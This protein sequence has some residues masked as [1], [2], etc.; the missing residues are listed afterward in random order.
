VV[1]PRPLN[2]ALGRIKQ[3]VLSIPCLFGLGPLPNGRD[4]VAWDGM[5]QFEKESS[6]KFY[7]GKSW[8]EVLEHLARPGQGDYELEEWTVLREPAL[9]YYARAH[10]EH[11]LA[12]ISTDDPDEFYVSQFFH[13]LY[14]LLYMHGRSPFLP[15]QTLA[16]AALAR[17]AQ[18]WGGKDVEAPLQGEF[19]QSNVRL[20][21]RQLNAD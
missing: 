7:A 4:L 2:A 12:T 17:E 3:A 19:V 6:V 11:L 13:Q 21:L 15:E 5:D 8:E 10:L 9:S 16:L 18:N 1:A 20:F 14:Q